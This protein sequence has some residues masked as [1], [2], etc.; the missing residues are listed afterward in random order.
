M[1][2]TIVTLTTWF[3]NNKEINKG[4]F[5]ENSVIEFKKE[6]PNLEQIVIVPKPFLPRWTRFFLP[7]KICRYIDLPVSEEKSDYTIYRPSYL[8]VPFLGGKIYSYFYFLSVY[9]FL[10]KIKLNDDIDIIH[11]HGVF[12][13]SIAASKLSNVLGC[14]H[15]LHVHDSYLKTFVKKNSKLI[16]SAFLNADAILAVSQFQK[17]TIKSIFP[18]LGKIHVLNNSV[19]SEKF[20]NLKRNK[21]SGNGLRLVFVGNL[22]PVKGIDILIESCRYLKDV[23]DL[24]IDVFGG[25]EQLE[26][27]EELVSTLDLTGVITFKG[28]VDNGLLPNILSNYHGLVLPSRYE[29]FGVVVIEALSCG[30]PVIVSNA[31]ALP[32]LVEDDNGLIFESENAEDLSKK[33]RKFSQKKWDYELISQS[34]TRFDKVI[35][36]KELYLHYTGLFEEKQ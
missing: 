10:K 26:Y 30:L 8:K 20:T 5:V 21:S 28:H 27:L 11:S 15:V 31:G 34:A 23:D 18:T 2:K 35:R 12:P 1:K 33:I 7:E 36:A 24:A 6:F 29:T 3:P 19:D 22:L 32:E 25:G 17:N 16:Y 13:D 9:L 4:I 14:K